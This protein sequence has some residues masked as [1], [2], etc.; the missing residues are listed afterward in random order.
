[1]TTDELVK[2]Y[3]DLLIL[4]YRGKAKARGTIDTNV[5]PFI[6]DQ[7]PIAVRD[8]FD[9]E[10]AI[11]AQLNVLGKYA[12]VQRSTRTFTGPI[13]LSDDDFR[14]LIKVAILKNNS[15]SDLNT[16][17]N[18]LQI[19]FPDTIR[20][21]DYQSMRMSYFFD[22]AYG[23]IYLA[24]V[25]VRQRLL[26][27]PMGVNLGALIYMPNIKSLFCMRTYELAVVNG[28]GFNNYTDYQTDWPWLSY[29]NAVVG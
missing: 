26:P 21:F 8:A 13:T 4:Q 12:G 2:I 18:L 15:G 24:E 29:A 3:V 6:M 22:S 9:V 11:G 14:L 25:L 10:T 27:R 19:Y 5:R 17:Q 16:I 28:N 7:L 1:M 20:V 23:S